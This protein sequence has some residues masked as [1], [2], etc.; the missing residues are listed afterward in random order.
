MFSVTL[1]MS[2]VQE[3]VTV[4]RCWLWCGDAACGVRVED[5]RRPGPR[6][7]LY[8]LLAG[9]AGLSQAPAPSPSHLF[10]DTS[11]Q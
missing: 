7:C 8:W 11:G 4:F 1:S 3:R 6:L 9:W 10:S 2:R 5:W